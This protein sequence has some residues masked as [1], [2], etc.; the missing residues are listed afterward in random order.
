MALNERVRGWLL[1]G[2]AAAVVG[3]LA[4][5]V[6]WP[7]PGHEADWPWVVGLMAFPVA[8]ALL[9]ARRPGNIIGRLLGVVGVSAGAIFILSGLVLTYPQAAL[10]RFIEAFEMVPAVTQFGGMLGLLHLFPTGRPIGRVHS[11]IVTALWTYIAVFAVLGPVRPGPLTLTGRPNPL[12]LGPLWLSDVHQSGTAGIAVFAVLGFCVVVQRWRTAA[13]VERAQLKWFFGGATW[14][15]VTVFM[16]AIP[17][18]GGPLVDQLA[19]V[20]VAVAFWSLPIA[21][22][23]AVTRY[24]L[25]D[26]DRVIR[27]TAGYA[28]VVG[29]LG[30]AYVTLV[31]GLQQLLPVRN[32]DLV[33]AGSTLAVAAM[34]GPVRA[35]VQRAVERH[36]NRARYEMASVLDD[37]AMG[38]HHH[39]DA[40][41][42]AYDV[43]RVV[44]R[45]VEPTSVDLWLRPA[46]S[47]DPSISDPLR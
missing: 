4:V 15:V 25:F 30:V 1:A 10:S 34:F 17:G 21:V 31:V 2:W 42:I 13:P 7:F 46:L 26:I 18:S 19:N 9:L 3:V 45:T 27:R 22:V 8:A 23:I 12:G 47:P 16:A 20:V 33:V 35:R 38:V 36:F 41:T 14:T 44:N 40:E 32:S 6:V 39:V 5:N 11:W 37:F 29:L 28:V 43:R 24:H